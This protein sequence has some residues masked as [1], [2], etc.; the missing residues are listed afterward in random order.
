MKLAK[1]DDGYIFDMDPRR[2][3]P[4]YYYLKDKGWGSSAIGI[5]VEPMCEEHKVTT[6]SIKIW[7]DHLSREAEMNITERC[8]MYSRIIPVLLA[9][10]PNW[11]QV[12][13]QSSFLPEIMEHSSLSEAFTEAGFLYISSPKSEMNIWTKSK[14]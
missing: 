1:W 9:R 12:T 5:E 3:D 4:L 10:F 2:E 14:Q 11:L 8:K 7:R 6:V 13:L